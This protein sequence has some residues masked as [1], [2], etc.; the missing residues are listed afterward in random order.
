[1]F[2][3]RIRKVSKIILLRVCR[4][5][6]VGYISKMLTCKKNVMC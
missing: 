6:E 3:V 5:I 1:M 4:M 2:G